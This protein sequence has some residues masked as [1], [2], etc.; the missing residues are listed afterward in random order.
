MSGYA[1]GSWRAAFLNHKGVAL[2]VLSAAGFSA[3]AIFVKLGFRYGASAEAL[4]ALRML[5]ALPFFAAMLWLCMREGALRRIGRRDWKLV[6]LLGLCGYYLSS[7]FDFIGL[8]YISSAL[9]RLTLFL[10][11]TLVLLLSVIFLGKRYSVCVWLAVALAYLGAG[12][13]L[14]HDLS[15]AALGADVWVGVGWV[16][17]SMLCYAVYVA[18]SGEV[19]GRVGATPFSALATLVACFAVLAHFA[20]TQPLE[21]LVL[22]G[23]V[24]LIT[25]SMALFSTVFPV[26]ALTQAIRLLGAGRAASISTLG[27]VLTLSM[28]WTVLGESFSWTQIAG[29][30]LVIAGVVLVSRSRK[31]EE[32][33]S[34]DEVRCPISPRL[35]PG[36]S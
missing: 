27:P 13:A 28:G 20:L 16:S 17:L 29:A 8:R 22:P 6:V 4:L 19:V 3:K 33:A 9:E 1:L 5:F 30:A 32:A 10:Y 34:P 26:W 2:A 15:D 25:L 12:L 11:P 23:E 7:L 36:R 31:A 14:S 18:G 21:T 35:A 24:Y